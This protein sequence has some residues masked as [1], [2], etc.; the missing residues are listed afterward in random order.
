MAATNITTYSQKVD[1]L[2]LNAY[3]L[4]DQL[5]LNT[6]I[7]LAIDYYNLT[8]NHWE[9]LMEALPITLRISCLGCP[10]CHSVAL[11]SK[12]FLEMNVTA[13]FIDI[14]MTG[15]DIWGREGKNVLYQK[16]GMASPY[17]IKNLTNLDGV[18]HR[19]L[20]HV[21]IQDTVKEVTF[22]SA[23]QVHNNTSLPIEMCVVDDVGCIIC[24]P[25]NIIPGGLCCVPIEAA[26]HQRIKIRPGSLGKT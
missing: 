21:A 26:Y 6:S 8:N 11:E 19:L 14:I 15:S 20:C 18:T 13:T 10:S 16:C 23:F 4:S 9:P 24:Q 2:Q 7:I 3:A 22:W 12:T 1:K 25:Y 17:L 5:S